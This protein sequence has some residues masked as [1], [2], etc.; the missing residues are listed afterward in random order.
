MYESTSVRIVDVYMMGL[1][2]SD[3]GPRPDLENGSALSSISARVT[4][5]TNRKCRATG[6]ATLEVESA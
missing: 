2:D 5:A 4:L 3:E 6:V 1:L